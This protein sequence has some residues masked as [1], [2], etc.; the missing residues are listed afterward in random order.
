MS[1]GPRL[2]EAQAAQLKAL[3]A[4]AEDQRIQLEKEV[5]F[6]QSELA[7]QREANVRSP[8]NSMKNLVERLKAQLAQKEKQ[9]KVLHLLLHVRRATL[10]PSLTFLVSRSRCPCVY[11]SFPSPS[12]LTVSLGS[13]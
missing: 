4:D 3:T 11:E 7:A 13:L 8:S 5:I 1:V 9:L 6:L 2:E 12:S 10:V